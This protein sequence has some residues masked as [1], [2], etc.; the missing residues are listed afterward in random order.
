MRCRVLYEPGRILSTGS[1]GEG[2]AGRETDPRASGEKNEMRERENCVC[3]VLEG[4]VLRH[5]K[6]IICVCFERG[7]LK[8]DLS[9]KVL[10][11]EREGEGLAGLRPE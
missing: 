3:G 8:W 10:M 11:G 9:G 6:C 7:V 2:K 1:D 4:C 5:L